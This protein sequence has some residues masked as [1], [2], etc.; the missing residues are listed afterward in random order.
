MVLRP[1][2][3]TS[4]KASRL[5]SPLLRYPI[6][7]TKAPTISHTVLS[8]KPPSIQRSDLLGSGST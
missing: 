7:N 2:P 3:R 6:E 5:P 8:E 4:I 1:R